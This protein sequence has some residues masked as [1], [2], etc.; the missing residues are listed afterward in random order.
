MSDIK[1]DF[2]NNRTELAR[3]RNGDFFNVAEV[4]IGFRAYRERDNLEYSGR[5][6]VTAYGIGKDEVESL[7]ESAVGRHVELRIE[8]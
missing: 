8:N 5:I 3:L 7:I 4:Y 2:P 1:A 6:T